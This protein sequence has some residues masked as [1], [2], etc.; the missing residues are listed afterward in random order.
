MA[1]NAY[2]DNNNR[3]SKFG[4]RAFP[5]ACPRAWNSLP[6]HLWDLDCFKSR[7]KTLVFAV[8]DTQRIRSIA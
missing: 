5:V 7:L 8:L 3:R 1:P 4:H 2:D 6:D